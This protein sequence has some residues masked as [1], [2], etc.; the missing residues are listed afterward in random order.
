[1]DQIGNNMKIRNAGNLKK[2]EGGV[3][4]ELREEVAEEGS[5]MSLGE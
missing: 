3:W 5:V 2:K 1:M 4:N